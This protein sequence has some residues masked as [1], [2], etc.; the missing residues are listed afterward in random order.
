MARP[1]LS[2]SDAVLLRLGCEHTALAAASLA[3]GGLPFSATHAAALQ[4]TLAALAAAISAAR[5]SVTP[6]APPPVE[7]EAAETVRGAAPFPPC[8]SHVT[9]M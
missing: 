5:A 9:A 1:A 8:N 3:D 2:A 6:S 4:R 7:L